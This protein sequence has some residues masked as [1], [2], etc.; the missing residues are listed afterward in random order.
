MI[1]KLR[2]SVNYSGVKML[3]LRL[4]TIY[5]GGEKYTKC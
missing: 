2:Q 5:I 4:V 3:I 1:K